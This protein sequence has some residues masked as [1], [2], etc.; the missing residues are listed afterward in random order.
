MHACSVRRLRPS[1]QILVTL[2]KE[3]LSSSETSVLTTATRRN[4]P[5]DAIR[6]VLLCLNNLEGV[7]YLGLV[8]LGKQPARLIF[9]PEDGGSM[10]LRKVSSYA[11]YTALY[12]RI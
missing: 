10:L 11:N 6:Q 1:S 4:I 5:E 8:T 7:S 9:D 3:A 2:M 12:P